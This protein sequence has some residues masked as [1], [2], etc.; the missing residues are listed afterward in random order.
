MLVVCVDYKTGVWVT[1]D[2]FQLSGIRFAFKY[3][4]PLIFSWRFSFSTILVVRII[5]KIKELSHFQDWCFSVNQLHL[6]WI[7]KRGHVV[8]FCKKSC[9]IHLWYISLRTNILAEMDEVTHYFPYSCCGWRKN[10]C[11]LKPSLGKKVF[12]Y[13]L[14]TQQN[15]A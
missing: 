5:Y 10:F 14:L 1:I 12:S 6:E 2:M 9:Y 3:Y 15:C 4:M 13:W 7:Q 11:I 8:L